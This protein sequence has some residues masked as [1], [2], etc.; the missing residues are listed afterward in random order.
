[1][2]KKTLKPVEVVAL[3]NGAYEALYQMTGFAQLISN[4]IWDGQHVSP[5]A[6][7]ELRKLMARVDAAIKIE[8]HEVQGPEERPT[9]PAPTEFELHLSANPD[10]PKRQGALVKSV[11]GRYSECRGYNDTRFVHLPNTEA[12]REIADLLLRTY[13]GRTSNNAKATAVILRGG[14][15]VGRVQYIKNGSKESI[16]ACLVRYYAANDRAI[17]GG[18]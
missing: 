16:R 6:V 3:D 2:D 5:E 7:H 9:I 18:R 17:D 10:M 12:G 14:T 11:G 1:M 4:A 15:D 13:P 8:L